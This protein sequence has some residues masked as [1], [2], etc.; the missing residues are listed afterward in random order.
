M[1][2]NWVYKKLKANTPKIIWTRIENLSLLGTPDLLGYNDSGTFFTVELK[3][4]KKNKLKFSPHQI[5]FHVA[6]PKNTFILVKALGQRSLKLVPGN[7]IQ[8]LVTMG[9]GAWSSVDWIFIQKT[10][11]AWRLMLGAWSL[12]LG[13]SRTG[14]C[15]GRVG[16][17]AWC[18]LLEACCLL[19]AACATLLIFLGVYQVWSPDNIGA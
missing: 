14:S 3:V 18:L 15:S 7:K 6:H 1:R 8:E 16:P 10:F 2:I 5:A 12:E 13:P 17:P 9:H 4:T 11:E 19:L